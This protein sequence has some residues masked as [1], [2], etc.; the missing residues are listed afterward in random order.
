MY[1]RGKRGEGRNIFGPKMSVQNLR[2]EERFAHL[3]NIIGNKFRYGKG[4]ILVAYMD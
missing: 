3:L 1:L 2:Y 4:L